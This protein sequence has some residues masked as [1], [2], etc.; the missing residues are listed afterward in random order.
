MEVGRNSSDDITVPDRLKTSE[1]WIADSA[2]EIKMKK[3]ICSG[4]T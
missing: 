1:S 3:N 4:K 2:T